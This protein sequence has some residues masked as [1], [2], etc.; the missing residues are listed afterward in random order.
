VKFK[1]RMTIRGDQQVA[2]ESFVATDLYAP[3]LKAHDSRLL[4]AIAAAEGC[5]VYKTDTSQAFLYGSMENDVVYIR[6]PDWWPEPIPEGHC[7]QLLK[8]IYGTR[9]AARRW[10][11]HNSAW[12]EANG[13]L[14][15]NSEKT[16]FMK[17]EGKHFIIHG[18]FVDDMMHIATNNKLKNEFMETYSRD[19]NVTGGDFM[20]TFLGMDIEQSNRSI[21]LRL[22]HYVRK[23]LSEYKTYI[24]KSL[25]PKRVPISPSFVQ[26][27]APLSRIHPNISLTGHLLPSISLRLRGFVS[28]SRL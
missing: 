5:S 16:I 17:S 7:L 9:Q 11:K 15:V 6:A 1:V 12:M 22:D 2:D 26:K 28:I 24:K 21:K 8:S 23:K 13:Y 4:L 27:T 18:L 10:H 3:V 14:A 20:K 25:Q 19:L